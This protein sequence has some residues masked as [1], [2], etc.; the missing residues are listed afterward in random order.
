VC[1]TPLLLFN[2]D[3]GVVLF[4]EFALLARAGDA[5]AT[6]DVADVENELL[7]GGDDATGAAGVAGT[8]ISAAYDGDAAL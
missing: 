3:F 8:P 1:A 7:S 5:C 4:V 2:A 6:G